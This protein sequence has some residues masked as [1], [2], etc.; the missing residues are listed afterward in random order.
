VLEVADGELDAV[1]TLVRERM[2]GAAKLRV[3]L[4]VHVGT[5]ANWN[6]AAH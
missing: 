3:P 6:D 5:G 2:G 1:T 4:D